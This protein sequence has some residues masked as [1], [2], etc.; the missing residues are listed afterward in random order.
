MWPEHVPA[1]ELWMQVQ[2]QWQ[3][4]MAGPTGLDYAGV[5]ALMRIKRV[6]RPKLRFLQLQAMERGALQGWAE[7]RE[8]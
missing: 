2:T 5:E 1:F 4:S 7:M 3:V 8:K 6:M